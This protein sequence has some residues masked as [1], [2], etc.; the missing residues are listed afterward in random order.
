[1]NTPQFE[2]VKSRLT[3]RAQPVPPIYAPEIAA[4]AI[5]WASEHARREVYVGLPTDVAIIGNKL[6][7]GAG[8]RYLARTGFDSQQTSE[9]EDPDRPDNLWTPV[10]EDRDFG[11]HGRFGSRAKSRS[12][13][14][15]AAEHRGAIAAGV[16]AIA[17]GIGAFVAAGRGRD[18]THQLHQARE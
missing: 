4:H 2:C 5:V 6:A 12:W 3:H 8:D 9:P 15:W 1:M 11:A 13:Q 16:A 7:P 17:T 14:L 10:D 18:E